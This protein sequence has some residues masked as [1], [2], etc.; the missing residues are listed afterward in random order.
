MG[1]RLET[2]G[3]VGFFL[4]ALALFS[5]CVNYTSHLTIINQENRFFPSRRVHETHCR[6]GLVRLADTS[7]GNHKWNRSST[8]HYQNTDIYVDLR[9][10]GLAGNG[11]ITSALNRLV[12]SLTS[13][14]GMIRGLILVIEISALKLNEVRWKSQ[15]LRTLC[16][17][18]CKPVIVLRH[19]T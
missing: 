9:I 18:N 7:L 14:V 2:S 11:A 3:V 13:K 4:C 10:L 8:M 16:V 1:D 17:K 15:I 6:R 12:A 5:P 19:Q